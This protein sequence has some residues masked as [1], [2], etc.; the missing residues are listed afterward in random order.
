VVKSL[1]T[2]IV[3]IFVRVSMI[4]VRIMIDFVMLMKEKE[5]VGVLIQMEKIKTQIK[6][7]LE[8][9][10]NKIVGK[11]VKRIAKQ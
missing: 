1:P 5:R 2:V 10:Q 11:N 9:S 8:G 7:T 6:D 3:M 4:V